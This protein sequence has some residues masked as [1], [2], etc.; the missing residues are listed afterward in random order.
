MGIINIL[1]RGLLIAAF[2]Y[3]ATFAA[4]TVFAATFQN[5]STVPQADVIVCLGAGVSDLGV[6]DHAATERA[7]TCAGLFTA[8]AAPRV[9]FT[10]GNDVLGAPSAA[11]GMSVV[12]IRLGVP[13][14]ANILEEKSHSTLQN[15]L[16]SAPMM[17][18]SDDIIL[19]TEG[20]HLPRSKASFAGFGM[21]NTTLW[22]SEPFRRNTDGTINWK[23]IHR[24]T[25]AVW[26]NLGRYGVW[27]AAK[28]IGLTNIDHWLA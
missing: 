4:V 27:K 9:L 18:L 21:W 1:R 25:L 17:G 28:T 16:F 11:R 3:A 14:S 12:A 26:F 22:V 20:F 7:K 23:M 10:G 2:V 5:T 13:Q 15:A 19:V 24:E 8:G 6:I